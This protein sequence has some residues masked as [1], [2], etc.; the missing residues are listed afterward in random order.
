MKTIIQF[1][2]SHFEV[3]RHQTLSI[4]FGIGI[5]LVVLVSILIID[6]V[7]DKKSANLIVKEYANLDLTLS[8][9][10]TTKFKKKK[11]IAK[12]T[13]HQ[14]FNP[15]N[16]SLEVLMSNGISKYT[17]QNLINFRNKGKV[18]ETKEELLKVYG[19]T[20]E[21]YETISPFI[22]LPSKEDERV[23]STYERIYEP[24]E[25][26]EDVKKIYKPKQIEAFDINTAT[27]E[28][29]IQIRGIGEVF[30]N[31]ILKYRTGLGGFYEI[32]Q[33]KNTYGLADS[34]FQ[35]LIKY[36]EVIKMPLKIKINEIE[37]KDWQN[38]ILKSYQKRAVIAYRKQH[39]NYESLDDLKKIKIINSEDIEH[40]KH[41]IDFS[42]PK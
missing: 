7:S 34:T 6:T 37:V 42:I 1:I 17:A 9:I 30:A 21:V 16:A 2:K 39:G 29:L 18:Y 10:K 20:E 28:E 13:N 4:I 11:A 36:A 40:L 12:K 32:N 26:D 8:K 35:E 33:A 5:F 15:N 3:N 41:Y 19:M 23:Y 27:K 31:R 22:D 25:I 14:I 24:D 38:N